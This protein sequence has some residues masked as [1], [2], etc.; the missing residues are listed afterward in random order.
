MPAWSIVSVRNGG[1][2]ES[3]VMFVMVKPLPYDYAAITVV[4]PAHLKPGEKI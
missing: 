3:H 2:N 1:F 4:L